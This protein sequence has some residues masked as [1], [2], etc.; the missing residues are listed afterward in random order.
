MWFNIL[1]KKKKGDE[2][3]QKRKSLIMAFKRGKITLEEYN[4]KLAELK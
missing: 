3:Y 4:K 2:N 1:K